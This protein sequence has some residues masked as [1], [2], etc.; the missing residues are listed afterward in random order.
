VIELDGR[1]LTAADVVAVAH[2]RDDVTLTA[3]G[4]RRITSSY[5]R[6][7]RLSAQ[8]PLYGR[9]T[10][11]GANRGLSVPN[12][13]EHASSLLRSH[14]TSAGPL[15][16]PERVRAMLAVRINQLAAGGSGA[17]PELARALLALLE[18]DALPPVR[19]HG[20]VGTGDLAALAT[21]ALALMGEAPTSSPLGVR[22]DLGV[23]DALPLLSSNAAAIGDA[24]LAWADLDVLSRAYVVVAA[25]TF[26]AVEGNVEAFAETMSEVTPF[27][28]AELVAGWMR[29]LVGRSVVPARIQDPIST[30][31]MPQVHGAF[32]EAVHRMAGVVSKLA[33]AASENPL[34]LGDAATD[35]E[36]VMHHGGFHAVYL[37]GTLSEAAAA[38]M[39]TAKLS[40]SRLT[41]L[42]EPAYTGLR[43]FLAGA[44]PGASG[45]M[46][47][48]YVAASALGDLLLAAT[49]AGLQLTLLSRGVEDDASFASLA[50]RQVMRAAESLQI[51]VS[52][53]A[54]AAVR[55]LRERGL[56]RLP[57]LLRR[58]VDLFVD[59][60]TELADRDLTPDIAAAEESLPAL[61]DLLA[62]ASPP[63]CGAL[64]QN[65]GH[66]TGL[67]T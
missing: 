38:A 27:L 24:A 10:G 39:R 15:R 13:D 1:S 60:P 65:E 63:Q 11:V 55:A 40:L 28:G 33:N 23:H 9:S 45:V 34:V 43:P 57:D 46:M 56:T 2:R 6:A 7:E 22:M 35:D 29:S 42:N 21:T 12:P 62:D 8:R 67:H 37:T 19:E 31:A 44:V 3:A 59:I 48:E 54:V 51:V 17:S 30:R 47:L 64:R 53:E 32:V 14:A 36:A 26:T 50:A 25:L 58:A 20:G 4:E 16:A 18:A 52:C 66:A 5:S 61:A 49:P 41:T